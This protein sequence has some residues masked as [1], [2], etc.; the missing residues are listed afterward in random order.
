MDQV[1][2][3]EFLK[4]VQRQD[5]IDVDLHAMRRD[6][7]QIRIDTHELVETYRALSGGFK[8]LLW[9]GKIAAAV[10]AVVGAIAVF[11]NGWFK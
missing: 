4:S 10:T 8:V 11:R 2:R 5:S 9:L 3:E 7:E 6:L 1:S